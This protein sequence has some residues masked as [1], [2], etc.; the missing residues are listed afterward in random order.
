M[1]PVHVQTQPDTIPVLSQ[2]SAPSIDVDIDLTTDP[3]VEFRSALTPEML[4][5]L[6]VREATIMAT[7]RNRRVTK[8]SGYVE[9]AFSI[10]PIKLPN[11]L[12]LPKAPPSTQTIDAVADLVPSPK[13]RKLLKKM[14]AEQQAHISD[15]SAAHRPKAAYWA[16]SCTW[17][18]LV[19]YT[20]LHGVS[21]VSRAIRGKIAG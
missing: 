17:G 13:T 21:G 6:R 12:L 4:E 20:L 11:S 2:G 18:L 7:L 15:L 1:K 9:T 10:S 16:W 5:Y 19:W 8:W 14:I 3:K